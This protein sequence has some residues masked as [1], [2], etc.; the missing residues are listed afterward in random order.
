MWDPRRLVI[1]AGDHERP[2][3]VHARG[4]DRRGVHAGLNDQHR[5]I[6]KLRPRRRERGKQERRQQSKQARYSAA[7]RMQRC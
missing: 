5:L 2:G 3:G 1:G 4:S 7:L 6:V